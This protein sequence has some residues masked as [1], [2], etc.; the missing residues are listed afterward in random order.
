MCFS[1]LFLQYVQTRYVINYILQPFK[2]KQHTGTQNFQ[3]SLQ[4]LANE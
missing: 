4:R 1:G 2:P 3:G